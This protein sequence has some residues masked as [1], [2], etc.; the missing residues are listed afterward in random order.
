MEER[1]NNFEA[2]YEKMQEELKDSKELNKTLWTQIPQKNNDVKKEKE[3]ILGKIDEKETDLSFYEELVDL[4]VSKEDLKIIRRQWALN[5]N[6]IPQ[7]LFKDKEVALPNL[8]HFSGNT[9]ELRK[10][11]DDD[12]DLLRSPKNDSQKPVFSSGKNL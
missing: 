11:D 8:K 4:L 6:Q 2:S 10:D 12:F 3:K 5:K 7:D 9:A 1:L